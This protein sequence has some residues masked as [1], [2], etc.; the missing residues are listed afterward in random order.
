MP[1]A[2]RN[3]SRAPRVTCR[4]V[5]DLFYAHIQSV[6]PTSIEGYNYFMVI[7]DDKSRQTFTIP[8]MTK[9]QASDALLQFCKEYKLKSPLHIYPAKWK[10]DAGKEFKRFRQ[11]ATKK[12]MEMEIN[13][14]R[15]PEMNGVPERIADYIAQT[16]RTMII[17]SCLPPKLWRYAVGTAAYIINRL[18]NNNVGDKPLAIWRRE[19]LI[20]QEISLD[21]IRIW[22]SK[23]YIH[24][25]EEDRVQAEKTVP[26]TF[27][28]HL[29]GYEGDNGHVYKVWV[30]S[31]NQVKRS[32]DVI[33]KECD[34][35]DSDNDDDGRVQTFSPTPMLI[36]PMEQDELH[37]HEVLNP[38]TTSE[39]SPPPPNGRPYRKRKE[40]KRLID[41]IVHNKKQGKKIASPKRGAL[42]RRHQNQ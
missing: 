39:H 40:P 34:N 24:T 16:A 13:S 2:K 30:P 20:N 15:T 11:W 23:V 21:H 22:G 7:V 26:R 14:S 38:T 32:Q 41:E 5:V 42:R 37:V 19:L 36:V 6:K 29:V 12:G 10:L 8:L 25:H 9:G 18:P 1:K 4:K 17:D 31:T 33:I 27:L 35:D 3:L 28:G